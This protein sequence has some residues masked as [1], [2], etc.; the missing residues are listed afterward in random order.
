[1]SDELLVSVE[2]A[3]RRLA[4]GRSSAYVLIRQGELASIKIGAARRV[5][6]AALSEY[7]ERL[8]AEQAAESGEQP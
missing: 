2:E 4:I 3:A 5:P 1:M 8:Q 7:V 6:V